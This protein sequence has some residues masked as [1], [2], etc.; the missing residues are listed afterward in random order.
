MGALHAETITRMDCAELVGVCDSD[1]SARQ[2]AQSRHGVPTFAN[3]SEF[4][5]TPM[6]G[7]IITSSSHAHAD[8]VVAAADAR[9]HIFVEKPVALTLPET[10]WALAAV[11]RAG[12]AFQVG[13]QRRWD[14]RYRRIKDVI[15]SGAIGEPVL[16]KAH[17]RDP[18]AS[19]PA[20]WG[21][22]KNGG[23][24][25]NCAIH[26]YDLARYL[27]NREV[28]RVA[29]IGSTLVHKGLREVEDLDI[30]ITTLFFGSDAMATLE[31][32]RFSTTGFEVAIEVV[33]TKGSVHLGRGKR[34]DVVV[35]IGDR[36]SGSVIDF[37]GE[38][39]A[40][41]INGFADA[42]R[43][44]HVASP[45]ID[46]ARAAL[47]LAELAR[48]SYESGGAVIPVRSLPPL[49]TAD[50]PSALSPDMDSSL[51]SQQQPCS[52]WRSEYGCAIAAHAI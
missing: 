38:A 37:F 31:W 15:D 49:R 43:E 25:V 5:S 20:N 2:R 51:L 26:D 10:D 16:L 35:L 13:F 22:S 48:R 1:Q 41:S 11:R 42:V 4:V 45:G 14:P 9:L 24:F 50:E 18:N 52:E 30:C 40:M 6:D 46:D 34:Q 44:G 3:V 21:L 17:G 28:D 47:Y 7:V 19:R 32:S 27:M 36:G 8:H 39:Y 12:V 29:A 33:G 23:L